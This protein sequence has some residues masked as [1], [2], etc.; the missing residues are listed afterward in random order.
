MTHCILT[1]ESA[2]ERAK[3]KLLLEFKHKVTW[4]G[5]EFWQDKGGGQNPE[6]VRWK[7]K[8]W[9]GAQYVKRKGSMVGLIVVAQERRWGFWQ[10]LSVWGNSS[11]VSNGH[12][13]VPG[14]GEADPQLE[15]GG[16]IGF[17]RD[18]WGGGKE[19]V[20]LLQMENDSFW[21]KGSTMSNEEALIYICSANSFSIISINSQLLEEGNLK[22]LLPITA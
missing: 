5:Y 16:N 18:L 1:W 6:R 9:T 21:G 12:R 14:K 22:P 3:E 11:K 4:F 8:I 20:A 17:A 10:W 7:K 13:C 2:Q 19:G 15:R